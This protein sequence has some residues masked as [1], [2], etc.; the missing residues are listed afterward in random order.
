MSASVRSTSNN[1][2]MP[3]LGTYTGTT[4]QPDVVSIFLKSG[5]KPVEVKIK[6]EQITNALGYSPL[7]FLSAIPR[8][9][10]AAKILFQELARGTCFNQNSEFWNAFKNFSRGIVQLVPFIGNAVLYLHD[11]AR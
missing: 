4:D 6:D 9:G 8:I 1:C 10:K 7:E 11:L 2:V 5:H 3:I